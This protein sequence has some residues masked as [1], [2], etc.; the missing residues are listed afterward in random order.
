[1]ITISLDEYGTFEENVRKPSYI[2]GLIYDDQ[3]SDYTESVN[4]VSNERKRIQAYYR[5]VLSDVEKELEGQKQS[6]SYPAD[7]HSNGNRERDHQII[8]PVK[9]KVAETLGEFIALG[10]YKGK[11][12][13]YKHGNETRPFSGRKGKYHLFVL[14]KSDDGKK[15]LLRETAGML[16]N[17]DYGANRYIHM[18]GSIVNRVLFHNP[19]YPAGR[20]PAADIDIATR[21]A[22][23]ENE[24]NSE[25]KEE[26]NDLRYTPKESLSGHK[27][28]SVMDADIYRTLIAQEIVNTG[29]TSS[30]INSLNVKAISYEPGRYGMEFLYLSD[31]ICSMLGYELKGGSADKWLTQIR[32]RVAGL[33]PDN[34]NMI[35]GYDEIDND[36]T[37]AW[38]CYERREYFEALT[39]TYYAKRKEGAFAKH[40]ASEWFPYVEKRIAENMMPDYFNSCVSKLSSMLK[41]NNLDQELH[42]YLLKQ[43]EQMVSEVSEKYRSPDML[44]AVLYDLYDAA[45]SAYYHIGDPDTA[46]EYYD[47]CKEYAYYAGVD[48]FLR[49]NDKLIEAM[50]D[51]FEWDMALLLS[52]ENITNQQK[53]SAIRREIIT[54][55]NK[56]DSLEEAKAISHHA[57]ILASERLSD[58]EKEFRKALEMMEH[59]S[60]NYKITQSFLLHYY[61]DQGMKEAFEEEA[62]DY[63]DGK[64]TYH[65]RLNYIIKKEETIHSAFSKEYA[66]YVLIKGLYLFGQNELDSKFWEKLKSLKE[67]LTK[68]DGH[69]PGGHP[70]Q[71]IYKYL[72]LL[73]YVNH[74]TEAV[75]VF[76]EERK[77][78][79]QFRGKT[80]RALEMFGEAEIAEYLK[81]TNKRD[82]ETQKLASYLKDNF[83]VFADK[84]F[85]EDGDLRYKELE[86]TFTYMY[87]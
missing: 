36:F 70:W 87:R 25:L 13:R 49:T 28:Y 30:R 52:E 85:S 53:A 76:E 48:A 55:S 43:L 84:K 77:H 57:W 21:S 40:Y 9:Q 11:L 50:E 12:L 46:L 15:K 75:S 78:C 74:D 63:F 69:E 68:A 4:E 32:D 27:Y 42:F 80:I 22:G 8:A 71:I 18:A 24:I 56:A 44:A 2:G 81:D 58:A 45:V 20:M 66:L 59:G 7:L 41:T 19:L 83:R 47:K 6:L 16:V 62:T 67:T 86:N 39:I 61:A 54:K 65:Q 5:M 51:C 3:E 10:T 17:D 64:K 35:F 14:L 26:F 38:N 33:N 1:M 37:R 79:L 29:Y 72:K 60:A 23:D 34:Q 31:S 82:Q 73:A